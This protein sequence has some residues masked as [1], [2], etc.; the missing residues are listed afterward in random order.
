MS[1]GVVSRMFGRA[2]TSRLPEQ[3]DR[4][5]RVGW[6]G[7]RRRRRDPLQEGVPVEP[8]ASDRF[9]TMPWWLA[10]VVGAIGAWLRLASPAFAQ[11]LATRFAVMS[12]VGLIIVA[13]YVQ[14]PM[15]RALL[16]SASF[17][18]A[19]WSLCVHDDVHPI[20]LAVLL[21]FG[22]VMIGGRYLF[23]RLPIIGPRVIALEQRRLRN[24]SRASFSAL[25]KSIGLP[26]G[27]VEIGKPRITET[28]VQR[29][30][31]LPDRPGRL[32]V[33]TMVDALARHARRAGARARVFH[34][35][36][37]NPDGDHSIVHIEVTDRSAFD[38]LDAGERFSEPAPRKGRIWIGYTAGAADFAMM[39]RPGENNHALIGG[40][41]GFGK[42]YLMRRIA[43]GDIEHG[44]DVRLI[45]LHGDFDHD[46]ILIRVPEHYASTGAAGVT[47]MLEVQD[48]L[49][50]R[51]R[52]PKR[53]RGGLSVIDLHIDEWAS[54]ARHKGM[55]DVL[56]VLAE[57]G[58][59]FSINL[60]VGTQSPKA[61]MFGDRGGGVRGQ[62]AWR[63]GLHTADMT[64]SNAVLGNGRAGKGA[65]CSKLT[66]PGEM[67]VVFPG[68]RGA[69]LHLMGYEERSVVALGYTERLPAGYRTACVVCGETNDDGMP[70]DAHWPATW[71]P[72][73]SAVHQAPASAPVVDET[74]T[75]AP[76][77][78]LTPDLVVGP[79]LRP[80][81][82]D[83]QRVLDLMRE[84]GGTVST[85][86][87][88]EAFADDP[89]PLTRHKAHAALTSLTEAGLVER[90]GQA[91]Y[92][93]KET[94]R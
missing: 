25:R 77:E 62:F 34:D 54:M 70:C 88:V 10:L 44:D 14:D 4:T 74:P 32:Q 46:D 13:D 42:S 45:D 79:R 68:L 15:R 66:R 51:K 30:F 55:P 53:E 48:E 31:Q 65:D 6:I 27:T 80:I 43:R 81:H 2:A 50:R 82:D 24:M 60:R 22:S 18:C 56:A 49:E 59:K 28:G 78:V 29:S 16:G 35:D 9:D 37:D 86:L 83:A 84:R 41:S 61:G 20:V 12:I 52:I 91:G 5:E 8:I 63:F 85:R 33:A 40:A 26:V 87:V 64:E 75:T 36:E 76:V 47:M 23:R 92:R 39:K 17:V 38:R 94:S 3:S 89:V 90:A 21:A 19:W 93:L 67:F 1:G 69:G 58:R 7:K 57:E 71:P 11:P 73:P 72:R